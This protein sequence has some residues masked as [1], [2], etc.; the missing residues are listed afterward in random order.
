MV[1]SKLQY[2]SAKPK[3]LIIMAVNA[4]AAPELKEKHID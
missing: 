4:P 3:R 1:K 2:L